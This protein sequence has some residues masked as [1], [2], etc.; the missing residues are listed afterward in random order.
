M[1]NN[2]LYRMSKVDDFLKM[3]SKWE[4][5]RHERTQTKPTFSPEDGCCKAK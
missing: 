3:G 5:W 4:K 1:G 2:I